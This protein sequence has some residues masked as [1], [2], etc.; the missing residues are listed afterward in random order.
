MYS[1]YVY[2][3]LYFVAPKHPD[4]LFVRWFLFLEHKHSSRN[5]YYCLFGTGNTVERNCD[6][7]WQLLMIECYK[8]PPI[9]SNSCATG[10]TNSE[11]IRF[12]LI[13]VARCSHYVNAIGLKTSPDPSAFMIAVI[14][15]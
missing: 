13:S 2:L 14:A 4:I 11:N 12:L 7:P 15:K 10:Y 9:I 5:N 6:R 8:K 3:S 1:L